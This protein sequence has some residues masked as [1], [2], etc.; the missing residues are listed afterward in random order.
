MQFPH[1]SKSALVFVALLTALLCPTAPGQDA[2]SKDAQG[3]DA[4]SKDAAAPDAT[5]IPP[6]ASPSD[7]QGHAQVGPVTIAADFTSHSVVTLQA[8]LATDDYVMVE[9]ALFGPPGARLKLSRQ[10][11][12]LRINGSKTPLPT[13][14][15]LMLYESLKDPQ[16]SPPESKSKEDNGG[17]GSGQPSDRNPR[18]VRPP[19]ELVRA[20]EVRL[21]KAVLPEGER[22]L[23]EAGLIF[24]RYGGRSNGVHSVE[25]L[26]DGP[27]GKATLSLQP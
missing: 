24:F 13:Q 7:Y 11:F 14:S 18:P 10:D 5:P 25:L 22:P 2:Q 4:Q 15:Y 17:A 26:Y 20:M 3:K 1:Q 21:Q 16:W 6:R 19:F 12:S 27:A 23:P 8:T 9:V